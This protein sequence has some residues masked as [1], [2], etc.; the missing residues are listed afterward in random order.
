MRNIRVFQYLDIQNN[1]VILR[2]EDDGAGFVYDPALRSQ[3]FGLSIMRERA[4]RLGGSFAV[5]SVPGEGT[6]IVAQLPI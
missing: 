3:H 5:Q 1:F 6:M 4:E 2:I